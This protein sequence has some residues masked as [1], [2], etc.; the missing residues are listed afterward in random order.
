[1]SKILPNFEPSMRNR[2]V[3]ATDET[4]T[5]LDETWARCCIVE[6]SR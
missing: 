1:M 2:S 4:A 6:K 5:I 3:L